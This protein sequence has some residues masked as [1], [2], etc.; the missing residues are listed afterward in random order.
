MCS[1]KQMPSAATCAVGVW[2]GAGTVVRASRVS[3][4]AV[5]SAPLVPR[6]VWGLG[7]RV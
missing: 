2:L 1:L 3:I 4:V 7:F 5:A 6:L